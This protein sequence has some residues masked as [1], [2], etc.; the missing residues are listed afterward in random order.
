MQIYGIVSF[1][2]T[3]EVQRI[4]KQVKTLGHALTSFDSL[5]IPEYLNLSESLVSAVEGT[6]QFRDIAIMGRTGML[7]F[8]EEAPLDAGMRLAQPVAEILFANK[9]NAIMQMGVY[10]VN[11]YET[12]DF[13]NPHQDHFDG[14]IMIMTPQGHRQLDIYKKEPEDDVFTEVTHSYDLHAGSILV[15]NG[16][17]NLGHAAKCI[18]GPSIS[19]VA[20]IPLALSNDERNEE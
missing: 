5:G 6:E 1:M 10:A 7:M 3:Q 19:V 18:A 20:D 15:L 12:G 11:Q 2:I 4:S 16:F 14:T 9:P 17:H 8:R 13:F